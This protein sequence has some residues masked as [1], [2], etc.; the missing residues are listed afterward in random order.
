VTRKD[1]GK[2]CIR[3]VTD[4]IDVSYTVRIGRKHLMIIRKEGRTV[5]MPEHPDPDGARDPDDLDDDGEFEE[6]S[7]WLEREVAAGRDPFPAEREPEQGISI[8]LGDATDLDPQLLAAICGPD[9]LGGEGLPAQFG[10]DAAADVLAPTPV[11][12]ALL[13]VAVSDPSRLSD[14]QLVGVRCPELSGQ[15]SIRMCLE[16]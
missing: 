16:R 5:D 12:A 8:S 1:L 15:S 11:L 13:E 2:I 7:A 3:L 9:G 6:F 4:G 10:Q 14:N